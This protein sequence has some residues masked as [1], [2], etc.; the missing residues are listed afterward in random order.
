MD[1]ANTATIGLA[2]SHRRWAVGLSL[3][4]NGWATTFP[5]ITL[6]LLL[7]GIINT[8][9]LSNTQ[10]GWLGSITTAGFLFVTLPSAL[11]FGNAS[12][13]LLTAVSVGAGAAFTALHGFAPT[14][15][16]LLLARLGFSLAFAL[17]PTAQAL[18]ISR[19]FPLREVSAIQGIIF[20]MLGI[21]EFVALN[22]T[23]KLLEIT[24]DW[25]TVYYLFSVVG[26]VIT[27]IWLFA[28]GSGHGASPTPAPPKDSPSIRP[29]F[30]HREV[31]LIG[32]SMLVSGVSWWAYLTFWPTYMLQTFGTPLSETGFLFGFLS[33]ATV[34]TSL[35]FG[36]L[37][38][39]IRARRLFL[40]L[41]AVTVGVAGVGMLLTGNFWLLLLFC[42]MMGAGWGYVP[43]AFAIPYEIEGITP[44]EIA[45]SAAV[46]NTFLMS[47]GVIGP[48]FVGILSDVTGSLFTALMISAVI[49]FSMALFVL[50][51]KDPK[52]LAKVP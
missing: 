47:G 19:W 39:R 16:L 26:V 29:V 30:R 20:G 50:G 28:G 14:F 35:G 51:I 25:R 17:R 52:R 44:Q 2:P 11:L 12:P 48:A 27:G 33:V 7:P 6:G 18:V 8:F 3:A 15:A 10:A 23:P 24:G 40:V 9:G 31:W 36:Y 13:Y 4:A 45:I 43:I 22:I 41:V 42:G 32:I 1:T 49:P 38:T 46:I 34:P 37:G 5:L 21:A